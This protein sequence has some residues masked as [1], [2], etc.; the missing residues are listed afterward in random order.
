[1]MRRVLEKQGLLF[2]EDLSFRHS[3]ES[4]TFTGVGLGAWVGVEC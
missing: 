1:M 2:V 4:V 3:G